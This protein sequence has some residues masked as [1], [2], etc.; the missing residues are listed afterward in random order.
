MGKGGYN[1]TSI[2]N[3]ALAV[4]EVLN[5][6]PPGKLHDGGNASP[7]AVEVVHLCVHQQMP[8]WRCMKPTDVCPPG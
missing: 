5:G 3:S 8:Y 1:L 7:A 6:E 2:S 4:T